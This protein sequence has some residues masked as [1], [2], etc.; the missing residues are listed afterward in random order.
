MNKVT[1]YRSFFSTENC[2]IC[3]TSLNY[4][5]F[6]EQNDYYG[7]NHLVKIESA[8]RKFLYYIVEE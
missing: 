5:S 4:Q 8:N 2:P 3:K 7:C 1:I 6:E